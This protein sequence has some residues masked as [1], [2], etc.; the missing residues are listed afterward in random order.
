MS[1]PVVTMLFLAVAL[2]PVDVLAMD[3]E[4][5][6]L[7]AVNAA[8]LAS[9]MTYCEARHGG[10]QRGSAGEECFS[11]ARNVLAEFGLRRRS[12]EVAQRCSD[13]ETFN[14]CL[15]PEVASLVRALTTEFRNKSL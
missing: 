1:K 4:R 10:L 8:A 7:Y 14:T 13:P 6:S 5:S 3:T 15:T 12:Q 2:L 9:A 11:K